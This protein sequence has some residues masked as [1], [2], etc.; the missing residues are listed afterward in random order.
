M[1]K[2]PG[3]LGD[4]VER[5]AQAVAA[6]KASGWDRASVDEVTQTKLR[7]EYAIAV[8]RGGEKLTQ[9]RTRIAQSWLFGQR[10]GTHIGL[11]HTQVV[12]LAQFCSVYAGAMGEDRMLREVEFRLGGKSLNWPDVGKFYQQQLSDAGFLETMLHLFKELDAGR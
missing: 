7:A 1:S 9:L 6:A 10:L 12:A 8:Q 11:N 4:P 5:V 3:T 2:P